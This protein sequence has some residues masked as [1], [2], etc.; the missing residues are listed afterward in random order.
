MADVRDSKSL[1]LDPNPLK[2][3]DGTSHGI[4]VCL[5]APEIM[6]NVLIG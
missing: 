6:D 1:Y 4:L 2:I 5:G 3:S